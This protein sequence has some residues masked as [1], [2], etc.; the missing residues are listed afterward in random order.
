MTRSNRISRAVASVLVAVVVLP[1]IGGIASAVPPPAPTLLA[2]AD[3]ASVTLPLTI[4]WSQV[5]GAGGYNWEVSLS[6]GFTS[7]IERN[8][9]LLVG[10][11]TTQ[12]IVSGLA[13]GTYFWHV[14]AVSPAVEPGA[15]SSPRSFTVTGAGAGVPGTATL[16]PPLNATQFHSWENFTFTW[17]SVPGAVGYILQESTDPTFPVDT[18]VRQVSINGPTEV[19]SFNPSIQGTFKAR[20]IAVSAN[21]LMGTPSNLVDFSVLDSNPFPAAPTL[22]TPTN[23]TSQQLPVSLSWTHVPNHQDLGYQVQIA[24]N[25]S[26]TNIEAT[27]QVTENQKIA[28]SLTTG[29]KFWRVRSQHGYIG[30]VEAYTAFSATGTFTVLATPLRMGA[31]TFPATKFSG[32]EALGTLELTGAAPAGGATV[33]LTASNPSLLPELPASRQIPA[34]T[35]SIQ[36]LVAPTGFPNSLRPMRVGFVTTPTPVTITA[37][38]NGSSVSTTITILPPQLNDTPFQ[39]FPQNATGGADMLGI[40]DLEVGCFAGSCDGLAPPGGFLVNLSSSSPSA[41]VPATMTIPAGAGGDQFP[42]HTTPVTTLTIVTITARAGGVTANWQIRLTPP[43][44]PDTFTLNPVD[45]VSGSSGSIRIPLASILGHDQLV[46]VTSSNPQLASVP[47]FATIP[48]STEFGGF[49]IA[50][51]AVTTRT[52]V[53]ITVTGGGVTRS[54]DLVVHPSL[55]T[56]TGFTVSP[57]SV[58]GGTAATGTVTLDSA[59]PAGG[60]GVSLSSSL[61]GA[62]SVPATVTVP[63]GATSASFTVTTFPVDNTTAQLT[64]ALGNTTLF[65]ALS[66]TRASSITLTSLTLSPITLVG[67]ASSTGTVSL[68]AAAPTGGAVVSLSDNSAAASEPASVTVPAGSTSRTFTVTTSAVSSPTAVN[69]SGSFGGATASA[70]LTVN[71]LGA[72]TLQTPANATTGVAQPVAF[73]WTD[74]TNSVD[75]EIQVDDTSTI[76]APFVANQIVSV[77]Q[78]SI[79]ALPAQQLWWRV[80]A[81]NAAGVFG[82]FSSTFRFTPAGTSTTASLSTVAVSPTSVVGGASSTGTITL[83]AAAPAGGAVVTLTSSNVAATVPASATI[84]AGATSATFPVTTSTVATTTSVTLTAT[85]GAVSRTAT[86]T[87]N[88]AATGTLPAPTP[89]SPAVDARFSPGQTIVFDWSDVAGAASYIIQ[90]D[91]QSDFSSPTISQT[92][93]VSTYSTSTL[94]TTRMWWRVRAVDASGTPGVWSSASRFEVK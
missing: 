78:A 60:L 6:S 25:S 75:Y 36:V 63:A 56:L 72:P 74:V 52:V 90:V 86:L 13:N 37:S 66:I 79:G 15:W 62:A 59:A 54:A 94:P 46:Q 38:Y 16:N 58:Q 68:S 33:T 4:S 31:V 71:P 32:G 80:R 84:A 24:T 47:A 21:G 18:R 22:V 65:A 39:L 30:S 87:V 69:I 7:V 49:A 83:T 1:V 20:V 14:Q 51:S 45:T 85:Y 88:P 53:T 67:G 28:S 92:V 23:G 93:S 10:L 3:G 9:A 5:A 70:T 64:A 34:G 57:T 82:P 27:Y 89:I 17:S 12:D 11:A 19:V 81:R 91:D 61:P 48:A 44:A 43:P 55:P 73:N 26:F 2:P 40:V 29:T 8:S 50:T 42:I 35:S 76:A 77:S 41:T